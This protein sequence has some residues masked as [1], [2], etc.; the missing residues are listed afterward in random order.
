M[1]IALSRLGYFR[2]RVS[3]PECGGVRSRDH[4]LISRLKVRFLH[5]S[6]FGRG[7][8]TPPDSSFPA[9]VGSMP[10]GR[11]H[12]AIPPRLPAGPCPPPIGSAIQP[13][14]VKNTRIGRTR[15]AAV[16]HPR[17]TRPGRPTRPGSPTPRWGWCPS[18]AP[19]RAGDHVYVWSASPVTWR[20]LERLGMPPVRETRP[21]GGVVSS[22]FYRIPFSRFRWGSSG[23]GTGRQ[24]G[25]QRPGAWRRREF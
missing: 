11:P 19:H 8:A 10:C 12:C 22:R 13:S 20:R 24:D 4:L 18:L 14:V 6:P 7:A 17:R 3:S 23:S 21:P 16:L 9:S 15:P 25:V 2:I 1:R 5:G